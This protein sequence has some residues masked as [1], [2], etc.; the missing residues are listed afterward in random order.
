MINELKHSSANNNRAIPPLGIINFIHEGKNI[1]FNPLELAR[2]PDDIR[3]AFSEALMQSATVGYWWVLMQRRYRDAVRELDDYQG[4]L[5][6]SLKAEGNY[7]EK[8]HG[9]RATEHGLEH[10][11]ATDR[12][13]L[14]EA[15][16]L[17]RLKEIVDQLS[18]LFRLL[19]RKH[20]VLKNIAYLLSAHQRAES[21]EEQFRRETGRDY[22]ASPA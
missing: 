19:E 6:H 5:Y 4:K 14:E 13:Y 15:A 9:L 21:L 20:D 22:A 12:T 3:Q 16:N 11:M 10:A 8:Y 7:G 2:Y 18:N 1:S 17:D